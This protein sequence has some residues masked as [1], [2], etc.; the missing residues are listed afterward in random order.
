MFF[1]ALDAIGV[2][3]CRAGFLRSGFPAPLV[4]LAGLLV[5]AAFAFSGFATEADFL[6]V[7]CTV[8]VMEGNPTL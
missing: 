6:C 7:R 1:E 2:G 8:G 3:V 4:L 5:R